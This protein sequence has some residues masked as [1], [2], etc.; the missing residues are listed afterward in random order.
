MYNYDSNISKHFFITE[1]T[2]TKCDLKL[3]FVFKYSLTRVH[4]PNYPKKYIMI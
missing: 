3:C 1:S 4:F 2:L